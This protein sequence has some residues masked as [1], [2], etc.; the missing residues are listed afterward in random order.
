M[1]NFCII[2]N[3]QL[4]PGSEEEFLEGRLAN[5]EAT[6]ISGGVY[7]LARR[8][9]HGE[10]LED[11]RDEDEQFHAGQTLAGAHPLPCTN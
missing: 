5:E 3:A 7:G 10:A 4:F 1:V 2:G 9:S 6:Q 11:C 8:W